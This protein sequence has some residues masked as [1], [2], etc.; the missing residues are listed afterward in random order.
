MLGWTMMEEQAGVP[1]DSA[2]PL[3]LAEEGGRWAT[4]TAL[5]QRGFVGRGLGWSP[6]QFYLLMKNKINILIFIF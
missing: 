2:G 3:E 4:T 1:I 6:F 5:W